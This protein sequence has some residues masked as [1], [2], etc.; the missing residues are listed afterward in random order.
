LQTIS[1]EDKRG[2]VMSFYTMAFLGMAPLG[3]LL[4]GTLAAWLG[5][6]ITLLINGLLCLG[7]AAF[8]GLYLPRLRAQVRPIYVR[9][10]ILPP[11]ASGVA[12]ASELENV[13]KE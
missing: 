7:G 3:S 2:R 1:A 9:L 13:V 10:N 6:Q 12:A 8:F 4:T 11:L 5:P